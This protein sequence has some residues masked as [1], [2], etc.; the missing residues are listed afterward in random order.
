M[1]PVQRREDREE[2]LCGKFPEEQT[3][4]QKA[5]L[6]EELGLEKRSESDDDRGWYPRLADQKGFD[7]VDYVM[8][9]L[10]QDAVQ[11]VGLGTG[12]RKI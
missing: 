2:L 7:L 3:G 5:A 12:A 4:Q 1:E 11:I 9:E 10:C 6:Q 8:D